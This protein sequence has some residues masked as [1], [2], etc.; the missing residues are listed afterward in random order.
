MKGHLRK[1]IL[2]TAMITVLTLATTAMSAPR[3]SL[4]YKVD[5]SL[6][7]SGSNAKASG[8]IIPQDNTSRTT[9]TV[10]LQR[11]NEVGK[12]ITVVTWTNSG[13]GKISAGGTRETDG[14][15]SYRVCATGKV[16]DSNGNTLETATAYSSI[17]P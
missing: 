17:Q 13:T 8:Y 14:S 12:W 2:V 1:L 3:L 4:I 15:S 16:I 7:L 10:K 5:G 9:I 6:T 11:R